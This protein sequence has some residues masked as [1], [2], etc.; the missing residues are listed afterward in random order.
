[1]NRQIIPLSWRDGHVVTKAAEESG[2]HKRDCL[3]IDRIR[4][5]YILYL[6][7][8]SLNTPI[9]K[10]ND[11]RTV[12]WLFMIFLAALIGLSGCS[13]QAAGGAAVGAIGAGGVYEYQA[14]RAM[15][16]LESER[17]AGT[18]TQEEYERRKRDIER[19][20]IIQ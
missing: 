16:E 2:E 18:I 7:L 15:Q 20:S 1:M 4:S 3:T 5:R 10:D 17:E 6:R 11:M 9:R 8:S 13:R 14:H 19:R 12:N